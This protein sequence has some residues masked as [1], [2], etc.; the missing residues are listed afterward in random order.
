MC[1]CTVTARHGDVATNQPQWYVELCSADLEC[2][3]GGSPHA[4]IR[5]TDIDLERRLAELGL[6]QIHT[7][8]GI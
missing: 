8:P 1:I 4:R 5:G 7:G 2:R 6:V 3:T